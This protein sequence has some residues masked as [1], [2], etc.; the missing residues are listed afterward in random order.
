M[1]D[2]A[3]VQIGGVRG[4]PK[5][6]TTRAQIVQKAS[7][8]AAAARAARGSS[9]A[10]AGSAAAPLAPP[11]ALASSS[12]PPLALDAAGAS[13]SSSQSAAAQHSISTAAA[14]VMREA[15]VASRASR[16]LP[17]P[18]PPPPMQPRRL[19]VAARDFAHAREQRRERTSPRVRLSLALV[20]L[21]GVFVANVWREE[22]VLTIDA[23]TVRVDLPA[24]HASRGFTA[25]RASAEAAAEL[26]VPLQAGGARA[27]S[28]AHAGGDDA[29]VL[30]TSGSLALSAQRAGSIA[31]KPGV[32]DAVVW[33]RMSAQLLDAAIAT[34]IDDCDH[35][36]ARAAVVH[37]LGGRDILSVIDAEHGIFSLDAE[38]VITTHLSTFETRD[39]AVVV[40]SVS[41]AL[42]D[43]DFA[44]AVALRMTLRL[45][46]P[47]HMPSAHFLSTYETASSD[48]HG[49]LRAQ[50]VF[51][52]QSGSYTFRDW[53]AFLERD[54]SSL[55]RAADG[56]TVYGTAVGDAAIIAAALLQEGFVFPS[57]ATS[58]GIAYKARVDPSADHVACGACGCRVYF[59]VEIQMFS[60]DGIVYTVYIHLTPSLAAAVDR[61]SLTETVVE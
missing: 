30:S 23:L 22:I 61:A 9:S 16:A 39:N 36:A 32:H 58:M 18:P 42:C 47:H 50:G 55:A 13:P 6:S 60:R 56:A 40:C 27:I 28:A 51:W 2:P 53:R 7:D 59:H 20:I 45:A 19:V 25:S 15:E 38:C 33:R 10:G 46:L 31:P 43:L 54:A 35:V 8:A 11:P 52:M 26:A 44:A 12:L 48:D 14:E 5:T 41:V 4:N 21:A 1:S 57:D 49:P 29:A 3:K 24:G 17:P 37:A 34:A